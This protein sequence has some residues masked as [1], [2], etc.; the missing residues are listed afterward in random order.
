MAP[1]QAGSE[2]HRDD[3][4]QLGTAEV[5]DVV[6]LGDHEALPLALG[7][8]IDGAVE[9]QDDRAAVEAQLRR[10]R[11]R[12]VDRP[13]RLTRRAVPE[14]TAMRPGRD[15]RDDVEL[16]AL[17][18]EGPLEGEVVVRRHDE[19]VRRAALAQERG[20]PGEEAVQ[21]AWLDRRLEARVQLVVERPRPL[22][23]RHV[24]GHASEI[25]RPVVGDRERLREMLGESLPSRRGRSR[26]RHVR[27]AAP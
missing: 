2:R 21:R 1:A 19:L 20:E 16:L 22:H 17:L 13:R 12:N 24:L 6:V 5:V 9:L 27:R 4:R 3:R 14:P 7:E 25:D 10:I 26:G 23:R 18:L 8:W 11:V 15:V